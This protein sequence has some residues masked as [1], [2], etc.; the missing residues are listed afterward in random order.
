MLQIFMDVLLRKTYQLNIFRKLTSP[1][2]ACGYFSFAMDLE[3]FDDLKNKPSPLFFLQF[4]NENSI[5]FYPFFKTLKHLDFLYFCIL[6][7]MAN[8]NSNLHR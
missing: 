1:L 3:I 8:I 6:L 4:I 2:A 7:Q 5:L